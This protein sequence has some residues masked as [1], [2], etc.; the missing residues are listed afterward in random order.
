MKTRKDVAALLEVS[1]RFLEVILFGNKERC[2]YTEKLIP[3]KH[4][5]TRRICIPPKNIRIL[6]DKL[7]RVFTLI[8]SV[9]PLVPA[10]SA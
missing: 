2:R 8:V 6:Q 10:L 9:H 4:G 1:T 5:G 3:K 7:L